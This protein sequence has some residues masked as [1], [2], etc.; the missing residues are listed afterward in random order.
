MNQLRLFFL[1]VTL[2]PLKIDSVSV[3][4]KARHVI[5]NFIDI[6]GL[7]NRTKRSLSQETFY[8]YM[9]E[10]WRHGPD[11]PQF[12]KMLKSLRKSD[13]GPDNLRKMIRKLKSRNNGQDMK[14]LNQLNDLE[15]L[16]KAIIA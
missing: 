15:D 9:S 10:F 4:E 3:N 2:W 5:S 14:L 6:Q 11:S 16:L 8:P 1:L 13:L 12:G 7:K